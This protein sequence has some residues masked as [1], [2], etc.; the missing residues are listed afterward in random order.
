VLTS[1]LVLVLAT[2]RSL[3]YWVMLVPAGWLLFWLAWYVQAMAH[4]H[5]GD[6]HQIGLVAVIVPFSLNPCSGRSVQAWES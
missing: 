2:R 4:T 1:P 5:E 6:D 3:V